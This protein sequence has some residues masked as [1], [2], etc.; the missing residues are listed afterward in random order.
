MALKVSA[1]NARNSYNS[2]SNLQLGEIL[3]PSKTLR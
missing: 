3:E 1:K 2:E